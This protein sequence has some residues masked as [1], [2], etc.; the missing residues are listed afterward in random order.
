MFVSLQVI[1]GMKLTE[2]SNRME[3]GW[4]LVAP[5]LESRKVSSDID[6]F[7]LGSSAKA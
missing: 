5:I 1:H 7:I 2:Q 6:W 4:L 3:K